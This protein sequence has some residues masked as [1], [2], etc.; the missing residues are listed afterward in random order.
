MRYDLVILGDEGHPLGPHRVE[1]GVRAA[2]DACYP[3]GVADA[4]CPIDLECY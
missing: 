3:E 1:D 4:C 2:L